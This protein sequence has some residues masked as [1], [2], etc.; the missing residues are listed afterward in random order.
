MNALIAHGRFRPQRT[1]QQPPSAYER[2]PPPHANGLRPHNPPAP[3]AGCPIGAWIAHGR[4]CPQRTSMPS[5]SA[6]KRDKT[7]PC[8]RTTALRHYGNSQTDDGGTAR[9]SFTATA[10]HGQRP[11]RMNENTKS[12]KTHTHAYRRLCSCMYRS[13]V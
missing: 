8:E 10:P 6:H 9:A 5:P 2:I 12:K 13:V 3:T 7:I 4:W 1:L 11:L